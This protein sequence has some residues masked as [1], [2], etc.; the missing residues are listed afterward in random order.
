MI[1]EQA[2]WFTPDDIQ[3][4]KAY[5]ETWKHYKKYQIPAKQLKNK[6]IKEFSFD[7][8]VEQ[9]KSFDD[10]FIPKFAVQVELNMPKEVLPKLSKL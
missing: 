6:N 5:I 10:K 4:G 3:V 1:L 8:M 2:Q 9:L 7:S